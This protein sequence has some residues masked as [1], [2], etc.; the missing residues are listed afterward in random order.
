MVLQFGPQSS[1]SGFFQPFWPGNPGNINCQANIKLFFRVVLCLS[2]CALFE[3]VANIEI[4][5]SSIKRLGVF[6][7]TQTLLGLNPCSPKGSLAHLLYKTDTNPCLFSPSPIG[8]RPREWVLPHFDGVS[9][10]YSPKDTHPF[11]AFNCCHFES[12][13]IEKNALCHST[14]LSAIF[15][16]GKASLNHVWAHLMYPW[17]GRYRSFWDTKDL[18]GSLQESPLENWDNK[19]C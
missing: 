18:I 11:N 13:K 8:Q 16:C 7:K 2:C 12:L 17:I 4:L 15:I 19:V 10:K 3:I 14:C 6:L 5:G 1:S 9:H